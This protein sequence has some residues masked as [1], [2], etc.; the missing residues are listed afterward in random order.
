MCHDPSLSGIRVRR[1]ASNTAQYV[2]LL[3]ALLPSGLSPSVSE[4]H[5]FSHLIAG[6]S[7]TFTAGSDFHRPRSFLN[8]ATNAPK[9]RNKNPV[10][11]LTNKDHTPVGNS[12]ISGSDVMRAR[13]VLRPLHT[14][15]L[16]GTQQ[17]RQQSCL[18]QL[19]LPI[20]W[21]DEKH[22]RQLGSKPQ[23][24]KH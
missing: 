1:E 5:R 9:A 18:R 12:T 23:D 24:Q 4:L 19:Q 20:R 22:H 3:D 15:L 2:R 17:N 10:C 14:R 16:H 21:S 6:G 11:G 7:R 8:H 13:E